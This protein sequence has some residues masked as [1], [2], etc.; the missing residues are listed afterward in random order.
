M[1]SKSVIPTS[2]PTSS[3]TG[4][5]ESIHSQGRKFL[6]PRRDFLKMVGGVGGLMAVQ[7]SVNFWPLQAAPEPSGRNVIIFITD[8]QRALQWFPAGWAEANLPCQTAL[9][10]TG[11]TFSRAFTNTAMCTP[12]RTTLFTGL[13]PA[14]HLSADTLSEG[15]VQSET[16]HQLNPTYPNLG[17]VMTAAGYEMAYI[18]KYHLSK[19]VV[20]ADGVNIWDDIA[21][22]GFSQWDPPD[23]GR[24][25]SLGDY[26]A[27][28]A[29]NDAR[30][31]NDAL[32]YLSN[33]ISN[34]G[35][36]PFCLVV[37]LVNPHDVLGYPTNYINGGYTTGW[38]DPTVPPLALPPTVTENLATNFKPLCQA[39]YLLKCASLGLLSTD[40]VKLNYLNFYGNLMKYVDSQFQQ[41]IDL[42]QSSPAGIA[43]RNNTWIVRTS[44]HGEYG[45]AHGGL[46][47]KSFTVYDEAI[48]VPLIWSNPVDYPS[49]NGQQCDQLVGHVDFLPTLCSMLGINPKQYR[50]AGTDY[51]SL[52]KNPTTAPAVQD[53]VLF[54]YD[55]IWCGQNAAGSPNGIVVAPNRI[56]AVRQK[57]YVYA[58]YF[59][60]EGINKPQT[61]FYDLR[62]TEEG[63]TDTD[64]AT[65]NPLQYTNLSAWAQALRQLSGG[66]VA[67]APALTAQRTQMENQLQT[68]VH[69]KLQPLPVQPA[70][71]PQNFDIGQIQWTDDYGQPQAAIQITWLSRSSTVY[72]L[73]LSAD[74]LTWTNLGEPVPGNNGPIIFTQPLIELNLAYRLAWHPNPN[75]ERVI[76]PKS[77]Q[78]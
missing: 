74:N 46:R 56:R 6:H 2:I 37:S 29:D 53:Y 60:G 8:Q 32:A 66:A 47:Q 11:V 43:I 15:N 25:T 19:G 23:A 76:E 41:I 61:E 34:P 39:D 71:P 13:Y 57:D 77:L 70:V 5:A 51:S 40:A 28:Y 64:P 49:G 54:T 73:Q 62:T 59:D 10:D 4:A 58:Y 17:A 20:Q 16:E 78:S 75:N 1:A 14:Q 50:F 68:A 67:M 63:G 42:L 52:I 33:K 27:G 45:L 48:R 18:G 55:D 38:I 22:Y 26:G 12:A 24:N 31:I 35:G 44:D 21:R 30:Y 36:K 9:A 3:N 69:T 72:Q 7:G 65:G